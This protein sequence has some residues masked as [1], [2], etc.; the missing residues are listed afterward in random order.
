LNLR[1][2]LTRIDVEDDVTLWNT[3]V[4]SKAN[5]ACAKATCPASPATTQSNTG[6]E[7]LQKLKHATATKSTMA[8]M[9]PNSAQ[10]CPKLFSN[11]SSARF[12]YSAAD[13][14]F[15]RAGTASAPSPMTEMDWKK[16][17]TNTTIEM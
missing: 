5:T 6:H 17:T 4:D 11:V 10:N 1:R 7:A 14:P 15:V 8:C 12:A 2:G 13:M 9:G 16:K 3:R